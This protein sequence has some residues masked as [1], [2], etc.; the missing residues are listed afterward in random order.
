MNEDAFWQLI[1]DCTPATPDPDAERLAAALTDRLAAGQLEVIVGFAEQLAWALHRLDRREYGSELSGDS[2]L[3]ARAAVVAAGRG[4]Y[5]AVFRDPARFVPYARDLVWAESLVY[6]P[7]EAYRRVTG[8]EWDR[9]TRYSHESFA[10]TAGWAVSTSRLI[11][12]AAVPDVF[13]DASAIDVAGESLMVEF[14]PVWTVN[15][16]VEADPDGEGIRIMCGQEIGTVAVTAELWDGPPPL[17]V[18]GWQ[19]VAEVSAS[20]ESPFMDFATN[21]REDDEEAVLPLPGPGG[22]RVRAHGRNRDD[23]HPRGD[24]DPPEEYL[25]QV[26][27][28]PVAEPTLHR[29]TSATGIGW[30]AKG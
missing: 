26:W 28:A 13:V 14:E 18:E 25:V 20:W 23:G 29:V 8:E 27:A 6:V 5:E 16:L 15:G 7:D 17:D 24:D 22:Y 19:D 30:H 1:H 10:N 4:A 21:Q 12:R 11:R 2:F 3:Y 9:D